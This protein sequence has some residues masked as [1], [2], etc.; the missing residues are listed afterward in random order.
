MEGQGRLKKVE[1]TWGRGEMWKRE[2][3][4]ERNGR[5]SE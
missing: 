4:K 2:E 1:E 3:R 5:G